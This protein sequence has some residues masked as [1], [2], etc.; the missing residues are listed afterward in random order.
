M[1]RRWTQRAVAAGLLALVCLPAA[2]EPQRVP[3]TTVTMEPPLGF[4]SSNRFSG[5]QSARTGATILVAEMGLEGKGD[6][7]GIFSSLDTVK[8]PFARQGVMLEE[9]VPIQRKGAPAFLY[10]GTQTAGGVAYEKWVGLFIGDR[11]AVVSFQ[12]PRVHAPSRAAIEAAYASISLG[13]P[14]SLAERVALLPFRFE[15][16]GEFRIARVIARTTAWLTIGPKDTDPDNDQPSMIVAVAFTAIKPPADHK[17]HGE[18]ALSK[19]Q[20][21]KDLEFLDGEKMQVAGRPGY[22]LNAK[23]VDISTGRNMRITQWIR[24]AEDY[25]RILAFAPEEDWAKHEK[26]FEALVSNLRMPP[27]R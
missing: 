27:G 23:A 24:Y 19:L 26:K 2:A 17:A 25:M 1:L 21:V 10:R 3:G 8:P 9:A 12:A 22:R 14:A 20:T 5:F 6:I 16:L 7:V 4:T 18:I 13:T 15:D 11:L